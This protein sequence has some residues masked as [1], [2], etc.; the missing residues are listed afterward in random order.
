M[1]TNRLI[2]GVT[3]IALAL[4]LSWAAA[5]PAAAAAGV[6]DNGN[7]SITADFTGLTPWTFLLLCP[8]SVDV[9]DCTTQNY[10]PQYSLWNL[11][12]V[13]RVVTLAAGSLDDYGNPIA[14]GT[15]TVAL[16]EAVDGHGGDQL[17]SSLLDVALAEP[18]SMP[19]IPLWLQAH[20]RW[21]ASAECESGWA[22]SW[23]SWAEPIT[24]GW[25]CARSIPAYGSGSQAP[26]ATG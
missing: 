22:P 11:G 7:G 17:V 24:G 3:S 20:G 9:A 10:N 16:W 8:A 21:G 13:D 12:S 18:A 6:T 2:A 23:Q 26:V 15:Y 25:V 19:A 14:A 5:P 1:H 4:G